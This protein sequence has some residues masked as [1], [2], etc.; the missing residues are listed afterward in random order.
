MF[1]YA[2]AAS[3]CAAVF[4]A[5]QLAD[6]TASPEECAV[7]SG[8]DCPRSQPFL[9]EEGNKMQTY[10][11]RARGQNVP[12]PGALRKAWEQKQ[13]LQ[14][15]KASIRGADGQWSEYGS[16]PL[17]SSGL[18]QTLGAA[19]LPDTNLHEYAGRVDDFAYDAENRRLFAAKGTGGIW[20]SEAVGGDV[21]TIG[22]LWVSV[23]DNLP[24]LATGGVM[25]TAAGGGTLVAAS[26]DSVMSTGAYHGIGAFWS[27]DLGET[28]TR[29]EGFPDD[30]LVFN[31]DQDLSNPNILYVASS[32]GLYRSDDAGR[33]F[34]NVALPTTEECAGNIDRSTHCNLA[35][36]VSDVIVQAPGGTTG[37]ECAQTGCP[38]LAAVGWRAGALTYPDTD[39][40]QSPSNGLYKSATGEAGSF[41]RLN[42]PTVDP[43]TEAG[44]AAPEAIG[45][46][47]MGQAIGPDQDH[48][49]V[50]AMV[51]DAQLLNG[52]GEITLDPP[53][54]FLGE[55]PV[56]TLINGM[57]M[58]PDFGE[59]WIR[60][61]DS[62]ELGTIPGPF[63][64]LI[65]PGAQS[66][67]N[68]W[69]KPDPTRA[70]PVTGAPTRM[71]FGLEEVFQNLGSVAQVPLNGTLQAGPQ[72]FMNIGYYFSATGADLTVHPDQHAGIFIPTDLGG[73]CVFAGNDGGVFRQCALPGLE[74]DNR[75]WG[76]GTN[77][78]FYTL[79][80]YGLGVAKDG[81]VWF[82][83]QDNG[84][85]HIEPDTGES[86]GDFGADGFY[87]EVHPDN[88]DLAYTESQ[89]GGLQRTDDR[90]ATSTS[91][92]PPYSRVNFANWFSMDP[93]DGEHMITLANE[94]YETSKAST[95]TGSTWTQVYG[96]GVNRKAEA[97]YTATVGDVHGAA[98]YVG[99]CG[100]CGV[101]NNDGVFQNK[102]A[103]NVGGDAAPQIETGNGWHDARAE[104][105]PNRKILAIEINPNDPNIV[106]VGLGGYSSGLRGPHTF[107]EDPNND[108]DIAAGNLFKSVD[109]GESFVSIQGDLPHLPV[110]NILYR[111][112]Q[113]MIATDF[114]AF[115][116]SD[117]DGSSYAPVGNGLPNV[118]VTMLKLQPGNPNVV[119]ASTFGRHIWTYEFPADSRVEIDESQSS[120]SAADE[121]RSLTATRGGVLQGWALFAL[122]SLLMLRR[123]R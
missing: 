56:S 2:L 118:P 72:D 70:D 29:S 97:L 27:T 61:A 25:W 84:S 121:E 85:G 59:N 74:F 32:L 93:L 30:A 45:R 76:G 49:Y 114:G 35:N 57:Y 80:P 123:R 17:I 8:R 104:G 36:I 22:D 12:P 28:W 14:P 52:V 88:S 7:D 86:F 15:A 21:S 117:T 18:A 62:V 65:N 3:S 108:A 63:A 44:F 54:D 113:L 75:L 68:Q 34:F 94:V 39:I 111:E 102:L 112:G 81:T 37:V 5:V 71:V 10:D 78:G 26:G 103:T 105:L 115:I 50:Y 40:P 82:G 48:G 31:T 79:L 66:W 91:I 13:A 89:N 51:Q 87:A 98:I 92:A 120:D 100:D 99:A 83:L 77:T 20:M 43:A 58:S 9:N 67:Y 41:V 109:A 42:P 64:A 33:S 47:E 60:M 90:G 95:V 73:V 106:Y 107:G 55:A 119:F 23:G 110:N 4:A 24:T 122:F 69:I 16:T 101:T 53:L 1:R 46:I 96:M 6:F 38:V 116:S 19:P 11:A